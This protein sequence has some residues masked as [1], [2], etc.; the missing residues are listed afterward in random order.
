MKLIHMWRG[1]LRQTSKTKKINKG[2]KI[3]RGFVERDVDLSALESFL[4]P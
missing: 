1:L 4:R 3:N 2:E